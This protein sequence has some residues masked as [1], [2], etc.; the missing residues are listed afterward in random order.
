MA[1]RLER[2]VERLLV[3]GVAGTAALPGKHG[4]PPGPQTALFVVVP[5]HPGEL[6]RLFAAIG[7]I[8]VNVEDVR[9]EHDPGRP[10]G[11]LEVTVAADR[12]GHLLA[13]LAD[14]GWTAHG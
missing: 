13:S 14:R 9:I 1:T 5:D 3:K 8:G 12:A 4:R 11:L 7:E 10:Y 6:A 2:A